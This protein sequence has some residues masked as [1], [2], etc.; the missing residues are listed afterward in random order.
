ML[1]ISNANSITKQIL[2]YLG[3]PG[4]YPRKA[5]DFL[6]MQSLPNG[7]LKYLG[8]PGIYLGKAQDFLEMQPLPKA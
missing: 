3:V 7:P 6:E 1:L 2:E 5:Q 8:I 4:I